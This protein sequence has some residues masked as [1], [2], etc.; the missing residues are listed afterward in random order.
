M[1]GGHPLGPQAFGPPGV[2]VADAGSQNSFGGQS[3][4]LMHAVGAVGMHC[5]VATSQTS[6]GA[7]SASLMQTGVGAWHVAEAASQV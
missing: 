1:P 4:S 3:A 7:Q 2:Q 5:A 6:F